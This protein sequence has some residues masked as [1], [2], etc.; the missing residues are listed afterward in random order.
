MEKV[1]QTPG[2]DDPRTFD[3]RDDWFLTEAQCRD[4]IQGVGRDETAWMWRH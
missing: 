3:E 2:V 1:G 4:S